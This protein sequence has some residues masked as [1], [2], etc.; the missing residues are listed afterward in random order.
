MLAVA[1]TV[2]AADKPSGLTA[3]LD[4]CSPGLEQA[5][6]ALAEGRIEAAAEPFQK[7]ASDES[8][9]PAV[10]A[11]AMLGLARKACESKDLAG[12][13]RALERI[14]ADGAFPR[15]HRDTA[16]RWIREIERRE[17]GL[18]A[19]DPAD[20]RAAL[21][22]LA[23]PGVVFHVSPGVG[24]GGDGSEAKPFAALEAAR[25]AA[26]GFKRNHGGQLPKGGVRVVIH[27]GAYAANSTLNLTAEDS[28]TSEAPMVYAAD[29]RETPVFQGGVRIAGWRPISEVSLNER[30]EPAVRGR[31]LEADL[32]ALGVKDWGDATAL[33]AR[34]ELFCDGVP[35]TL[36]RWPNQGFVKTGEVL[37]KDK[38][39]AGDRVEGCRDGAFRYLEERPSRWGEEPDVRLYGYW[40]WD[41]YE[42]YQKV[43]AID[44]QAKTL[45]LAPP[46]SGYGYRKGQRYHALNLFSE[47]DEPGEW[48]LDRRTGKIYW[49]PPKGID[50]NRATVTLSVFSGPF[51]VMK[52]VEHV[53]LIG[54]AFEEARGDAIQL[55]G[56]ADCLIAG[57]TIRRCGGDGIVIEGGLR[58]GVFG[59]TIHTMGYGGMKVNGGDRVALKAGNHFVENCTVFDI[60]RLKRTYAPAVL[61]DG[62]GNRVA[63]NQ[64]ERMPSSAMRVEGNDHV[65]EL[66][67]IRQVVQ[68][69]DDQGGLDMFGNPLYRGV[70]IR[71]NHWLEIGGGT[72]C[73][74]A[75][76]RLDDM[77]SG[78]G[79]YGNV[80]ER[81]GAV[82]FGAVQ[83]H[84]GKD[85][86]V[87][88]NLFLD[89]FAGLSFS[90][91]GEK[92]WL[93]AV[94]KSLPQAG[95][96]PYAERYPELGG[97]ARDWDVN[98]I[99]RNVFAHCP[100]VLLR[101][102]GRER[103]FLNRILGEP[104]DPA[105]LADERILREDPTWR[106]LAWEPIPVGEIGP[107]EHPWRAPAK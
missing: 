17:K 101:D 46:Y 107:Y 56:G 38:I 54:L 73:G 84:G 103:T 9:P 71:W 68:E 44:A 26:R 42:E 67:R 79:I 102:G 86:W 100:S 51:V 95:T 7:V 89:C 20:Y 94:Q 58:H 66:N 80:F 5:A 31:V 78:V 47:I 40:Y 24:P 49:L 59:T 96:A 8:A 32:A 3:S 74:A 43:A 75:G 11:A 53:M 77:I 27:G 36:A 50:A 4:S 90:R 70:V 25:D 81:C 23:E 60:S 10:R 41:W 69:S 45:T 28:G 52:G 72:E 15:F 82:N 99:S 35:Q 98:Y 106:R 65:I 48:Y 61:L 19:R 30:L 104:L 105:V 1:G 22:V 76:V 2:N 13:V 16:R 6:T 83:I 85:N 97:L 12:A 63:H 14:A 92:R 39:M 62:C 33:R 21:P 55:E 93:E 34:P 88:G 87:E 18:T 29:A 37:G 91:W 64:F 57:S